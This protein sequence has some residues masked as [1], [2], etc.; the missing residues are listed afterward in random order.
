[1][2]K[3]TL[4]FLSAALGAGVFGAELKFKVGDTVTL[5]GKVLVVATVDDNGDPLFKSKALVKPE[6]KKQKLGF[7]DSLFVEKESETQREVAERVTNDF[8][9]HLRD[10][11]KK[12][13]KEPCDTCYSM[14]DVGDPRL[15]E[16][17]CISLTGCK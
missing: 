6:P 7:W 15:P 16:D 9:Q 11:L 14:M 13:G 5:G 3:I 1:M 12:Q 4:L 8:L 2:K 10:E 17:Y